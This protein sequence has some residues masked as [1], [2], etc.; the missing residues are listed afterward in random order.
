MAGKVEFEDR[1]AAAAEGDAWATSEVGEHAALAVAS[2][3][4][5]G[6]E[7]DWEGMV[8]V[9]EQALEE[10]FCAAVWYANM[11]DDEEATCDH[12]LCSHW[13]P[14]GCFYWAHVVP[15]AVFGRDCDCG[16][17]AEVFGHCF[18]ERALG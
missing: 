10:S 14:P 6:C 5:N 11:N 9:F 2:W 15:L 12:G 18:E 4:V 7:S 16:D 13:Q 1:L 8:Y 17:W 3:L